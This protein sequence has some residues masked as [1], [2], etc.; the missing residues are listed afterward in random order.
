MKSALGLIETVGMVAALEAAD[1]AVKA[2]NV[3]LAGYELTKGGGLVTVKLEGD[4]GAVNAAVAAGVAAANRVNKVY[5]SL[6]IPRPH[7]EVRPIIDSAETVGGAKAAA[8]SP[9]EAD[10]EEPPGA[11][12][13]E[14]EAAITAEEEEP[15]AEVTA[16][17]TASANVKAEPTCNLCNDINCPREKGDLKMKC[18]HYFDN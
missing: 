3:T 2:A 6:V 5:G 12:A 18:I 15:A 4:V 14:A 11:E 13:E 7:D 17:V 9:E 16:N 1:A 10:A 8:E